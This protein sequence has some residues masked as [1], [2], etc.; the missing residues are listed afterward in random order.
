KRRRRTSPTE[1]AILEQQFAINP[2]PT[3]QDR[4]RIAKILNMTP[5]ALQ[6]WFQNRR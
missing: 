5:R 2:L 6:V 3:H 4:N 1:L